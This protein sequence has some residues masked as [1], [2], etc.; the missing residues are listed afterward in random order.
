MRTNFSADQMK[1]PLIQLANDI[2]R[3]CVHCG[4]CNSTCPTYVLK[5]DE[6]DGPR[7]RISMIKGMFERGGPASDKLTLHIDRCLSCLSCTST[8]PSS[9]DYMHLVDKARVRIE[10]THVRPLFERIL[11]SLVAN[12]LPNPKI[13]RVALIGAWV[14]KPL[15]QFLPGKLGAI[16]KLAPALIPSPSSADRPH[17]YPAKGKQRKRVALLTGCAQKVLDPEINEATIRLLT[18]HGCEVVV[19]AGSGCCGALVH[20]MG[21]ESDAEVQVKANIEAWEQVA[22]TGR[23]DAVVINAS[24]CGTVIKDY[25]FMFRENEAWVERAK[26]ISSL[27]KDVTEIMTELGV[28][29]SLHNTGLRV[30]YHSACSLQHGQKIKIQPV[31]LLQAAGFDVRQPAEGHLCCGSAGT[32]NIFQPE[33]AEQLLDRKAGNLRRTEPNVIAAGNIGCIIQLRGGIDVP[34]VHTVSLLD[35]ATGGPKPEGLK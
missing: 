27:A 32:Y 20:H 4:F 29:K 9:V 7:G 2:L 1:T 31:E 23:L 35:W 15:A 3:R 24:G 18:R 21:R 14:V 5:G 28:N 33:I 30:T 11:R 34:V 8:C 13:F 10:E 6:L 12:V 25:G 17:V 19:S 26:N 22:K 16:A